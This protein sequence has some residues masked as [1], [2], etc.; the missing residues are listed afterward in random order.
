[1]ILTA[2]IGVGKWLHMLPS[3]PAL[4]EPQGF[5]S[6]MLKKRQLTLEYSLIT[7]AL[8]K[9]NPTNT[10]IHSLITVNIHNGQSAHTAHGDQSTG[11][12]T[13]QSGPEY[14]S[15]RSRLKVP[16]PSTLW[17][18]KPHIYTS[19]LQGCGVRLVNLDL[20]RVRR[21]PGPHDN[22][23][24]TVMGVH[25]H[26]VWVLLLLLL[27][28]MLLLGHGPAGAWPVGGVGARLFLTAAGHMGGSLRA[29]EG[30]K[31]V[32]SSAGLGGTDVL[33]KCSQGEN[34]PEV[35]RKLFYWLIYRL[36]LIY[37]FINSAYNLYVV[38]DWVFRF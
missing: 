32:N 34:Y 25:R 38:V 3:H 31:H 24:A 16:K 4:T 19:H 27:L 6:G 36:D 37:Y 22:A 2:C 28:L 12:I 23:G 35:T 10:G 14:N 13:T 20:H 17:R 33:L 9:T 11:C 5:S 1:M 29:R 15:Q 30:E 8:A 26:G 7:F 18:M 21:S